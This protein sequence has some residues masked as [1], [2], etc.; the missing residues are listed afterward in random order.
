M[1]TD[2]RDNSKRIIIEQYDYRVIADRYLNIHSAAIGPSARSFRASWPR[3]S[4]QLAFLVRD[5]CENDVLYMN[6]QDR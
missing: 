4:V 2:L 5:M 3:K 6:K 1:C